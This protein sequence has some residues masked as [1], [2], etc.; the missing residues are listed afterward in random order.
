MVDHRIEADV[1]RLCVQSFGSGEKA[2]TF[3]RAGGTEIMT[4]VARAGEIQQSRACGQV[5]PKALEKAFAGPILPESSLG[6]QSCFNRDEELVP[7][8]LKNWWQV[9]ESNRG[10]KDF[11]SFTPAIRRVFICSEE[12]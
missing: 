2:Q 7:Q 6:S 5:S 4:G 3:G 8:E 10:H 11:Q 12:Y 9:P 1:W